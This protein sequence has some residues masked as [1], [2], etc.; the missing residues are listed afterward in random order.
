MMGLEC[1]VPDGAE[2][3]SSIG[4]ALSLVRAEREL[5]AKAPTPEA[6]RT[7]TAERARGG[8]R[9]R[10]GAGIDRHPHRAQPQA[11]ALRAIATGAIGLQA[12]AMPGRRRRSRRGARRRPRPIR[13][14]RRAAGDRLVLDRLTT[15]RAPT[16]DRA[17]PLRRSGRRHRRGPRRAQQRARRGH[18]NTRRLGPVTVAPTVWVIHGDSLVEIATG[19]VG[20]TAEALAAD[21]AGACVVLVSRRG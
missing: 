19:D 16:G 10:C 17:R 15:T 13:L 11:R 12:G 21:A 8:H 18:Q 1:V 7:L 4:D 14:R 20:Q 9:R 3:I 6:I 2:V 5:A